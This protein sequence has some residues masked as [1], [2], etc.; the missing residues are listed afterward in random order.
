MTSAQI[1]ERGR[2]MLAFCNTVRARGSLA[3]T[4]EVEDLPAL[5][6]EWVV[7]RA[8]ERQRRAK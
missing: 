6:A 5:R 1:E 2:A 3:V 8:A 7:A 4:E